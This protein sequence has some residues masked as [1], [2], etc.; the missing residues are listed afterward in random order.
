MSIDEDVLSLEQKA[1][2]AHAQQDEDHI[3]HDHESDSNSSNQQDLT[4]SLLRLKIT[5]YDDMQDFMTTSSGVSNSVRRIS[6][7]AWLAIGDQYALTILGKGTVVLSQNGDGV[8]VGTFQRQLSPRQDGATAGQGGDDTKSDK[9]SGKYAVSRKTAI[10]LEAD[11]LT[12]AI[13][14]ADTWVRHSLLKGKHSASASSRFANYRTHPVTE[15]QQAILKRYK[16]DLQQVV[17]KGQAMD[18]ITR[19]KL[20]QGKIWRQQAEAKRKHKESVQEQRN[21]GVL[22]RRPT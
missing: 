21:L 17:N 1:S 2:E 18:L 15:K 10:P 13:Q 4:S 20:G 7:N 16:V 5:E 9:K 14:A 22:L 11:T 6:T 19:L 3:I 12:S 8:W